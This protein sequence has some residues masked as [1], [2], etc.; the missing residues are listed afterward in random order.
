[1]VPEMVCRV[2]ES[3]RSVP[4]SFRSLPESFR[5][6]PGNSG[7]F[8][9][10]VQRLAFVSATIKLS[11]DSIHP[12]LLPRLMPFDSTGKAGFRV[13]PSP[14]PIDEK[15]L[16][17]FRGLA[18]ANL[19]DAMGRFNVMDPGIRS[20][21]GFPLCGTAVTVR[22]RPA[23]NLMA[24]KAISV[25]RPGEVI[26]VDTC[27]STTTAL[28]GDLMCSG[29]AAK[30]LGGIIVDGAIRDIEGITKLGFPAY[31]RTVSPGACDKDG[32]GE[33]NIPISCAGAVVMPGDIVVGDGEG[34]VVIPRADAENVLA[35]V[36]ELMER[37]RARVVEIKGGEWVR[38]E[39]DESLRKK[40]IIP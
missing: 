30:K 21:T 38:A 39:I 11:S 5:A 19:A 10:P 32:P 9:L 22:T 33:I 16:D 14:P 1:M 8:L 23:D 13:L 18:T 28:F 37:E 29:A 35:L 25:A 6:V 27:G 4:E 20:R 36:V 12:S 40:G 2:P 7:P 34:V 3:F 26:V 31:S 24:H 15:L 17:C